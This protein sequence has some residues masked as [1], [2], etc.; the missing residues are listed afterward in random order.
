MNFTLLN[1][2]YFCI[3]VNILELGLRQVKLL[4]NSLIVSVLL[5]RFVRWTRVM[6]NLGLYSPLLKQDPAEY[7]TQCPVTHEVF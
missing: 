6:F 4:G 1:T 2:G 7:S 3:P 5:F